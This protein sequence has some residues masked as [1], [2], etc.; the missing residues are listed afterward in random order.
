M[1]FPT[2]CVLWLAA[3]AMTQSPSTTRPNPKPAPKSRRTRRRRRS[4]RSRPQSFTPVKLRRR[5]DGWSFAI[6]CAFLAQLYITGSVAA[7][8]K[9]VGRSRASAYKLRARAGAASFAQNWDAILAGPVSV[10]PVLVGPVLVGPISVE[11]SQPATR[12]KKRRQVADWRKLTHEELIWRV[13]QGLL[14]PVVYRGKMRG[15]AQ[16]PDNSALLR[17][18]SRLD[19]GN[20]NTVPPRTSEQSVN[21]LKP[22]LQCLKHKGDHHKPINR[23]HPQSH[24]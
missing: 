3:S 5:K 9:A 1:P 15:I 2:G 22:A 4:A 19:R 12:L 23:L 11:R 7:A 10:G 21:F 8:A 18:L 13:E 17:L 14:R 16:K 24:Q 20:A 6:Q